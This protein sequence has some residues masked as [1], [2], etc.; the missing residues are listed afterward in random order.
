M[1]SLSTMV[2]I[3][4]KQTWQ[5]Q[6]REC[7]IR[8]V[9]RSNFFYSFATFRLPSGLVLHPFDCHPMLCIAWELSK[10]WE[11]LFIALLTFN[12]IRKFLIVP[13]PHN[14]TCLCPS[15]NKC[16]LLAQRGWSK[17]TKQGLHSFL[18][19]WERCITIGM[20]RDQDNCVDTTLR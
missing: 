16:F 9:R 19:K 15:S 1:I 3:K 12:W 20:Q 8:M 18:K 4:S 10:V 5:V 6:E 14:H 13:W 17:S 7:C 2:T 11:R